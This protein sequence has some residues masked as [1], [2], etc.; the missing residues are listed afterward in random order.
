MSAAEEAL[1][2]FAAEGVIAV[3]QLRILVGPDLASHL[4][5]SPASVK[6]LED[7]VIALRQSY[8]W[9]ARLP[10][11]AQTDEDAFHWLASR[12]SHYLAAAWRQQGASEWYLSADQS[13]PT[14]G[15]PVMLLGSKEVSPM[16]VAHAWLLDQIDGGLVG[17]FNYGAAQLQTN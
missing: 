10:P 1:A 9:Q 8:G 17:A 6:V 4:D 2:D 7:F 15:T 5:L 3:E 14:F 16:A 13:A 12:V 11:A